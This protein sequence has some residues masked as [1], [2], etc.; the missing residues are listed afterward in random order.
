MISVDLET[1]SAVNLLTQGSWLYATDPSTEVICLWYS[2]DRG[3]PQGWHPGE[4]VPACFTTHDTIHAWNADGFEYLIWDFIMTPEHGFPG[5]ALEQWRCTA[6]KSR[7][8]NLPNKLENAARCLRVPQQ[9]SKRGRELIKL[10]C[11]PLKDG[12]FCKD[13][14]LLAEMD[15][16]CAQD[17][18]TEMAV[19]AMLREPTDEEW[20]DFHANMRVNDIGIRIDMD[21]AR[22]AQVYAAEE[23]ADLIRRIEELTDGEVVKARGEKL[24]DWV[25]ERLTPEQERLL[26]K[27]RGGERKLSLDRYNRGRLLALDDLDPD[28]AEVVECSDFAQKSSVGKFR[29]AAER[30]DPDTHRVHGAI[31]CNGAS[32]SG[33]YSSRGLQTHN[34]PR[35]CLS[36]P[37]EGRADL[38]DNIMPEDIV[39]YW[40][41]PIMTFLAQMLRPMIVPGEG[42]VFLVSDWSAIEGRCAPWLCDTRSGDKKLKLYADDAPVYEITAAGTFN[43]DIEDV[44]KDQRQV[45]KVQEL[46]FQYGGGANAF[47][48]MARGYGLKA[49]KSQAERYKNAWRSINPWAPKIWRDIET[50]VR[51]SMKSPGTMVKVG[52]LHY[53]CVE[54]ILC[55]GLT[56]FCQLPCGRLLTYPDVRVEMLPAPWDKDQLISQITV[57]RAAFVPKVGEKE[58]PRTSIYGGLLFE[59]A[60]QGTAASLLRDALKAALA[61]GLRVPLHVHDELVVETPRA[62]AAADAEILREVMNTAPAW[63]AGLPLKADV[64]VMERFGK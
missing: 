11:M 19:D 23:E 3:E 21:V 22:A 39:D 47:L 63:A 25:V 4:P 49:N 29:A 41:A 38:I 53:V 50:A 59:N 44:T 42:S 27:Y 6:F 45:G 2:V 43:V 26:V 60:V 62:Q 33:R 1:R 16:Y 12:T 37:V 31:M 18:R 58:W 14:A 57:L 20:A 28:V 35:D 24:K 56:L 61:R 40:G 34:F 8:N 15:E 55:G 54:D 52:R 9:K 48:A 32:A 10:L 46:A 13:P 64:D 7:C 30:A 36:D 51:K 17:V 5:V